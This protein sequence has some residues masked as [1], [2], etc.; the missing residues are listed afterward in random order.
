[1]SQNFIEK[2]K[3]KIETANLIRTVFLCDKVDLVKYGQTKYVKLDIVL[4][5]LAVHREKLQEFGAWLKTNR[6]LISK[7]CV[8]QAEVNWYFTPEEIEKWIK[9]TCEK[10]ALLFGV[11]KE[12]K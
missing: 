12:E 3:Q 5:I 4:K 10:F 2:I 11:E 9:K 8:N 1:M 6:P 7:E